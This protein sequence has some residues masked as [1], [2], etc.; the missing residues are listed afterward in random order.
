[1]SESDED[2]IVRFTIDD[3]NAPILAQDVI[4][5]HSRMLSEDDSKD[6]EEGNDDSNKDESN[7]DHE[8]TQQQRVKKNRSRRVKNP[9]LFPDIN[10]QVETDRS[11]PDDS[12]ENPYGRLDFFKDE[13][14][15]LVNPLSESDDDTEGETSFYE[16]FFNKND[17]KQ[18]KMTS[19]L[20]M[21]LKSLE[22]SIGIDKRQ[23]LTELNSEDEEVI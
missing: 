4:R 2:D 18:S 10:A 17:V 8:L 23:I 5:L 15:S 9:G 14:R 3:E 16:N 7:E 21:T 19:D 6:S 20:R 12:L 13:V 22:R 11:N 1:M